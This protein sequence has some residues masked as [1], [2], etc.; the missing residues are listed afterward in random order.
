MATLLMRIEGPM[1]SWGISSRFTERDSAR[2]PSKSGII[3]LVCAALG[4]PRDAGLSDL[5]KLKMGVRVERE[6][7]LENDFQTARNILVADNSK[8]DASVISTRYYLADAVFLVGLEGARSLLQQVQEAL[9][10]PRWVLYLGRKAFAPSAP[11]YLENGLRE[12]SLEASLR[13]YQS[14]VTADDGPKRMVLEAEDGQFW[15]QDVPINFAERKFL[16][17]KIKVLYQETGKKAEEPHV[18]FQA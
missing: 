1:Q 9:K 11:V 4:R 5:S 16:A 10:K 7:R 8:A 15:R 12:D 18:P 14:L 3:G 17:R 2:E 13:E 6:G